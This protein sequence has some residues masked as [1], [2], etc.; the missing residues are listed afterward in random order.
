MLDAADVARITHQT[1]LLVI[2]SINIDIVADVERLPAAGETVGGGRL[3]RSPGGKGANQAA[4]AARLGAATV[5]IGAVGDDAD[6][7][8]MREALRQAGVD[9]S[10]VGTSVEPTGTA[11]IA[12]DAAGENQIVV[13]AGANETLTVTDEAV[14]AAS[15]ILTQLEIPLAVIDRLASEATGYLAINAAPA[16]A[17][18]GAA[19]A[20]ADLVIVN[21]SEYAALPALA[22][23]QR[24]VVTHGA[25]GASLLER[26]TEIA[27]V[28][29]ERVTPID[30]VGAGDAFCAA[31]TIA[32]AGGLDAHV[33]LTLACA[34]GA[35]AVRVRGARPEFAR[36]ESYAERVSAAV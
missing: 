12:V 13:C 26:G 24:V 5:M 4:A 9:V 10:A 15:V 7:R 33:A 11:L 32:L 8:E 6:G 31:V 28:P 27:R 23:A 25:G 35:D 29:A 34:V 22:T 18:S 21:D 17:L 3:R 16:R 36:L 19:I 30:T 14:E 2:G 20:R 1:R